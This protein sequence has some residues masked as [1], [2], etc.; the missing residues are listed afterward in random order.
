[1]LMHISKLSVNLSFDLCCLEYIHRS[2][3]L[4]ANADLNTAIEL[5]TGNNKH[6]KVLCLALTQRGILNR[7]LGKRNSFSTLI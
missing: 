7:F 2:I 6:R 1:M 5:A 4:E 3:I